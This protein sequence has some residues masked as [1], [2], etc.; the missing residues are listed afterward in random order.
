MIVKSKPW[1]NVPMFVTQAE[2][3][4]ARVGSDQRVKI[5][6]RSLSYAEVLSLYASC[7]V[8]LSLHRSEG[9]GLHLMEAMSLGKVVVATNWSGNTDFMTRDDAV[10]IGYR[11]VPVNTSHG[12]YRSEVDRPGQEWAEA[13]VREAADAMR[14]LHKNPER[15]RALGFAAAAAMECRREAML[16]GK[17]FDALEDRLVAADGRTDRLSAAMRRTVQVA[18]RGMLRAAMRRLTRPL[19]RS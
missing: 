7:D 16:S 12:T 6:D 10:P 15:R 8:M 13:D 17:A 9:L 1:S 2:E 5:V 11:L 3:L 18:R 19:R 14:A 4:R